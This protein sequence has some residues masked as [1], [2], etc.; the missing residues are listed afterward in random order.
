M[1]L[2]DFCA[3]DFEVTLKIINNN[4]RIVYCNESIAWLVKVN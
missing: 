1:P 3:S 4:S 2:G